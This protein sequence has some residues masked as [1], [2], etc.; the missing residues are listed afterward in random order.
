MINQPDDQL[1]LASLEEKLAK[2][3]NNI[4][5]NDAEVVRL[6]DLGMS[7]NVSVQELHNSE[8]YLTENI[9]KLTKETD[10][11]NGKKIGLE[12]DIENLSQNV[13]TLAEKEKT[14]TKEVEKLEEHKSEEYKKLERSQSDLDLRIT[15]LQLA[16]KFIEDSKQEFEKQKEDHRIQV[17][18]LIETKSKIIEIVNSF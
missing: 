18:K 3:R 8:V 16:E 1:E 7:L 17:Q 11:L 12:K 4:T 13:D 6:K 2:I 9:E 14:L 10:E 15:N 5:L